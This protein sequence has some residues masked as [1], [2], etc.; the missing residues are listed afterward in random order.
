MLV[1]LQEPDAFWG[2]SFPSVGIFI[3]VGMRTAIPVEVDK[4][5]LLDRIGSDL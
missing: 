2:R 5:R 3:Y 1:Q 4:D